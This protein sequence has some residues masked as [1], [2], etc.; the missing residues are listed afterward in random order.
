MTPLPVQSGVDHTAEREEEIQ[1]EQ[2]GRLSK[3]RPGGR[4]GS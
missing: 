3:P 4:T 1:D 2:V